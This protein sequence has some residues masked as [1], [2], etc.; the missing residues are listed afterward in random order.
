MVKLLRF[1]IY[2]YFS[3]ELLT[4]LGIVVEILLWSLR[5]KRL[6]R[7]A[8]SNAHTST[9]LSVTEL[10]F[11]NFSSFFIKSVRA[12]AATTFTTMAAFDVVF[13][14]KTTVAFGCKIV[15]FAFD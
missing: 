10:L 5:N 3:I 15:I 14:G 7:I 9:A 1:L 2:F 12:M 11:F 13:L 6:K 4:A 8:R